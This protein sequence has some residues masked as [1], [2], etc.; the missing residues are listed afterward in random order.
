ME[1]LDEITMGDILEP[2]KDALDP[3]PPSGRTAV[4]ERALSALLAAFT[5]HVHV[6]ALSFG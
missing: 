3:V 4:L 2:L 1:A 5:N 6:H